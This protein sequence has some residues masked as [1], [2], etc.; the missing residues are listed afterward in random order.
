[1]TRV[2]SRAGVTAGAL[3]L[4]WL[5]AAQ[6]GGRAQQERQSRLVFM[7]DT[8]TG[9]ANQYAVRDQLLRR[10]PQFV[11]LLG[12]NIYTKG[13]PRFFKSRYD[14]VYAPLMARG[15]RFHAALGNHDV[16]ECRA[17][18][19]SGPLPPNRDAY[20]WR[21]P[22]CEVEEHLEHDSF[23]YVNERRYYSVVTDSAA[24]PLGEVFVLD[25]NTLGVAATRLPPAGADTAQ[26]EW[27]DR[28]LGVSRARWKIVTMHHPPH[29]PTA[30]NTF[31]GLG[32]GRIREVRLEN[33]LTPILTRHEV[34]VVFA[35]HNHFY[36]R[37]F[38]QDG[39][40]Y[41]VAGGGGRRIYG[42]A[43]APGY[44]AMGGVF[45][46]YVYVRLTEERVEY[47]AID[48]RGRSRD[49][50]SWAKGDARDR[51]LPPGTFPP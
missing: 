16:Y 13:R 18:A 7:G 15:V 29:T 17:A 36:A 21:D 23:G 25:T 2:A 37:M 50:G 42:Y 27:L 9:D 46:H 28:S 6:D 22:G 1:M 12:D 39:V 5:G 30:A 31:L 41:F 11:F 40:R 47:Y 8:G 38:P 4:L 33:Q 49:A 3:L 32:D 14:D 34:D 48:S 19:Y 24:A 45:L 20:R 43:S 51:L 10:P 44:V 26:I 35:G